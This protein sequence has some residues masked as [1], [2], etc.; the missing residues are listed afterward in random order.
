VV[1]DDGAHL[2]AGALELVVGE[3]ADVAV[4]DV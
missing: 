2:L 3:R 1:S 4:H